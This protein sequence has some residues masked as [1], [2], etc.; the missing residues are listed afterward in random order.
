MNATSVLA[1]YGFQ[2]VKDGSPRWR[3]AA[4]LSGF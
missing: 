4:T 2:T 3:S 1:Q